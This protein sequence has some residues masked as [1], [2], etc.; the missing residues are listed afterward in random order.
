MAVK[1]IA[2]FPVPVKPRVPLQLSPVL[3]VT[4]TFPVGTPSVP[5][6]VPLAQE[7][8]MVEN[9]L[10]IEQVRFADRL[11][12]ENSVLALSAFEPVIRNRAHCPSNCPPTRGSSGIP[13]LKASC[14][15]VNWPWWNRALPD[16]SR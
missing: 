6:K 2:Q 5:E 1:V 3:A 8:E 10:A 11:R 13:V 7:L 4:V 12:I 14:F 16:R 9:Y 15:V